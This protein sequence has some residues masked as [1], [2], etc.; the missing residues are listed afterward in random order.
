M[1]KK[2]W[3]KCYLI[4]VFNK[5]FLL[6]KDN[7]C[8]LFFQTWTALSYAWNSE[9]AKG[10]LP[11]W[12][13]LSIIPFSTNKKYPFGFLLNICIACLSKKK[14]LIVKIK[15]ILNKQ[16]RNRISSKKLKVP[17]YLFCHVLKRRLVCWKS[18]SVKRHFRVRKQPHQVICWF[19]I[20]WF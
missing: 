14:L 1:F 15:K 12:W 3:K 10:A 17:K 19:R 8:R 5:S 2:K 6:I 16:L 20:H 11:W 9:S 13:P 4:K 18:C 7:R